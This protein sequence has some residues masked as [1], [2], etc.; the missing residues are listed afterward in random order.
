MDL[1]APVTGHPHLP[2]APPTG[3]TVYAFTLD[4]QLGEIDTLNGRVAFL[5][6]VGVTDEEKQRMQADRT[7]T[8]LAEL[9]DADPLL[10]TDPSRA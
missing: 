10:V 7:A 4:P 2:D 1:R 6:A 9:A 5:Q 3:L 8:V